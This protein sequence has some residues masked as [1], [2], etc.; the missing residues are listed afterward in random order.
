MDRPIKQRKYDLHHNREKQAEAIEIVVHLDRSPWFTLVLRIRNPWAEPFYAATPMDHM[1]ND[2]VPV[3]TEAEG[4]VPARS[5]KT[6]MSCS[7]ACRSGLSRNPT[8]QMSISMKLR[9]A[10]WFFFAS[11]K[12][13]AMKAP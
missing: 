5:A 4:D 3:P 6:V 9:V 10:S 8:C 2:Y 1:I 12:H 7:K 11:K 13:L